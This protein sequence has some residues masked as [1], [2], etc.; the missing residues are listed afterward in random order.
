M[1]T[2]VSLTPSIEAR[3]ALVSAKRKPATDKSA[4]PTPSRAAILAVDLGCRALTSGVLSPETAGSSSESL[5]ESE[6]AGGVTMPLY[7]LLYGLGQAGSD[8]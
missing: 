5:S 7:T 3:P 1:P 6:S 4:V 2:T 8:L